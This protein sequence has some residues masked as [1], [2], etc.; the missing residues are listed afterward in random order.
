MLRGPFV[1]SLLCLAACGCS[2]GAKRISYATVQTLNPGVDARWVLEEFPNARG[3]DRGPDG[4]IRSLQYGVDDPRGKRQTLVLHFDEHETLTRKD[5]SG[6][7]VRPLGTDTQ[8]A[9]ITGAP[10]QRR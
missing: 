6:R 8:E 5:Y 4:R 2:G 9:R 3:V 10:S 7:L 1:A